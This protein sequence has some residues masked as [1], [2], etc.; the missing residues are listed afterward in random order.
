LA[1]LEKFQ[2]D[3]QGQLWNRLADVRFVMLGSPDPAQHMQPM[4]PQIDE[5]RSVIWFY[6]DTSSDLISALGGGAKSVHMSAMESDYQACVC[7]LLEEHRSEDIINEFWSP[8]VAAWFEGGKSDPNLTMLKFTPKD[9]A[10]WASTKNPIKFAWEIARANLK[11]RTPDV[12]EKGHV[13][14]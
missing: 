5:G 10:V 12:G 2:T 7:G 6:T 8:I 1:D 14:L 3:P 11:G 13:S 4:V 9:A